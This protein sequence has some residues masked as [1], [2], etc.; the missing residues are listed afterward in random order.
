MLSTP[1]KIVEILNS[2][3]EGVGIPQGSIQLIED[4]SREVANQM[5][6]LNQ[7]LDVLIPEG[8][9]TY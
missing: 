9:R 1:I 3:V 7:Y 6:K 2:S 5:L 8:S 4:T